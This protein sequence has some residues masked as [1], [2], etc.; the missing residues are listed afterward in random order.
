M[1]FRGIPLLPLKSYNCPKLEFPH[2]TDSDL[3]RNRRHN[4]VRIYG[5]TVDQMEEISGSIREWVC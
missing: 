5:D 3:C 1:L 2:E 4:P